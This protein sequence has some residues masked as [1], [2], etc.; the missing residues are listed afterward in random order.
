ME[1]L[2]VMAILGVLTIQAIPAYSAVQDST[3]INR[4]KRSIQDQRTSLA[5]GISDLEESSASSYIYCYTTTDGPTTGSPDA[6]CRVLLPGFV[7]GPNTAIAARWNPACDNSSCTAHYVYAKDC[8][9][10]HYEYHIVWGD[11]VYS[12][13]EYENGSACS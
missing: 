7:V 5:A 10:R 2:V 8:R 4:L 11:G 9:T 3:T 1:L 12:H 6:D 13:W